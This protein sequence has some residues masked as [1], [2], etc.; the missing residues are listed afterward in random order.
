ME[1]HLNFFKEAVLL[2]IFL[3]LAALIYKYRNRASLWPLPA[4][5][6][7]S[8]RKDVYQDLPGWPLLGQLPEVILNSRSLLEWNSRKERTY[9]LGFSVT[10]PGMRLIEISRP[11]WIE[12]VQKTNFQNYVK[13]NFF[14]EVMSDVFG[15]GIF[16]ADG[17]KWKSTRQVT[18]RI[19]NAHN[20]RTIV[21]PAIHD[22]LRAFNDLLEVKANE[23]SIVELD[24]FFHRFTLEAFIQMTRPRPGRSSIPFHMHSTLFRDNLTFG[25]SLL[26]SQRILE[27]ET[28]RD[29]LGLF[30]EF[31]DE[32]GVSLSRDELKDSALNLIIAGRDT[33]AQ[34]LSWTFFHL[35]KRP[36]LL[37]PIREEIARL[38]PNDDVMV[39]Y[40]SYKQFTNVLAVFYE[41]LRLHPS[42]PKNAKFALNHDKLPDGPLIQPGDCLRW[43]SDW[44][45]ARDPNI[46]G[47]DCAEFKPSRWIDPDGKL[48]Q[49]GQWKFHAFNG[50]PRI[51]IG[52]HLGTMEAVGVIVEIARRYDLQFAP[53]W[54]SRVPKI[55]KI[56]PQCTEQTPKYG[57]SLTLPMA[58]RMELILTTRDKGSAQCIESTA[59]S[60]H[61]VN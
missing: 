27:A 2:L 29:L 11:D 33:T 50:G 42:V 40:D 15:Q 16:V 45:M 58:E 24:D 61:K 38:I 3:R 36:E 56:T 32:K 23:G 21:A 39:D 37:V 12:H 26:P 19:L 7:T 8:E 30:M 35:T 13:G 4:A 28:P 41:A 1:E 22:T 52:M 43:R 46:W 49:Y 47:L 54:L 10:L 51:C 48:K 34:A 20:F 25:S 5:I 14:R 55:E 59:E 60:C 17:A 44:Q 57:S 18:A 9:G 53:G 31:S 6:G